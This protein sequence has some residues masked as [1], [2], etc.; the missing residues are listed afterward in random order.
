MKCL[1]F[2]LFTE[3]VTV[4]GKKNTV[5]NSFSCFLSISYTADQL[6]GK[7]LLHL[8]GRLLCRLQSWIMSNVLSIH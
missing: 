5:F 3:N 7:C 4:G 8:C 2:N 6:N 1:W